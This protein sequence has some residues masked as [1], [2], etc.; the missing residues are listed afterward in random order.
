MNQTTGVNQPL[1]QTSEINSTNA[2]QWDGVN[3]I[4][5]GTFP[6]C[7]VCT[8]LQVHK[9]AKTGSQLWLNGNTASRYG[10]ITGSGSASANISEGFGT[11]TFRVNGAAASWTTRG[12]AFTALVTNAALVFTTT[13]AD[14]SLWANNAFYLGYQ[15]LVSFGPGGNICELLIYDGTLSGENIALVEAY[16]A[17][18]WGVTLA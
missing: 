3:D 13:S 9:S 18:K 15:S 7:S 4:M 16:L 14:T 8:I 17:T 5:Q 12:E 11:P 2:T 6:N 1:Y 10:T